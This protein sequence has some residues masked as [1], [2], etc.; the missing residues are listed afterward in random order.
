M[1]RAQPGAARG[2]AV[3]TARCARRPPASAQLSSAARWPACL[4]SVAAHPVWQTPTAHWPRSARCPPP[5]CPSLLA[6]SPAGTP[7]LRSRHSRRGRRVGGRGQPLRKSRAACWEAG[8]DAG[9]G[10]C[11][12]TCNA[13]TA[14]TWQQPLHLPGWW[15]ILAR[16]QSVLAMLRAVNSL[17]RSTAPRQGAPEG[18]RSAWA[19][20]GGVGAVPAAVAQRA[21]GR[22]VPMPCLRPAACPGRPS[23]FKRGR[24]SRR[25]W[26]GSS[27][28]PG[29]S[30]RMQ[31]APHQ[32]GASLRPLTNQLLEAE[33][34]GRLHDLGVQVGRAPQVGQLVQ[35]GGQAPRVNP[36]ALLRQG[37]MGEEWRGGGRVLITGC[38]LD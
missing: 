2:A 23:A 38:E 21:A 4:P 27:R 30:P 6:P 19:G 12:C 14:L 8:W 36:R 32:A 37:G 31:P 11:A 35:R 10:A 24:S 28:L 5:P 7:R 3:P 25:Q 34:L 20:A 18:R 13:C 33:E 26:Q 9:P 15:L 1:Q 17:D 16:D 29:S 22:R